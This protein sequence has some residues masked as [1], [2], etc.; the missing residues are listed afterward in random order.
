MAART[1]LR[2][3]AIVGDAGLAH[4]GRVGGEP[5]DVGL[6]VHLQHAGLVGAVGEDLGAQVVELHVIDAS[7][8]RVR[9][10]SAASRQRRDIA[11]RARAVSVSS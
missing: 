10:Q 7:R 1:C 6:A 4:Q 3:G 9:I 11:C 8:G 5:L 2:E